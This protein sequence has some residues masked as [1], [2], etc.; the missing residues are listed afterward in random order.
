[1]SRI[2]LWSGVVF[3]ILGGYSLHTFA[4]QKNLE[5]GIFLLP[6]YIVFY[7]VVVSCFFISS[8]VAHFWEKAK[9]KAKINAQNSGLPENDQFIMKFICSLLGTATVMMIVYLALIYWRSIVFSTEVLKA[10]FGI[11]TY[12]V[13]IFSVAVFSYLYFNNR[14]LKLSGQARKSFFYLVIVAFS[15]V[16]IATVLFKVILFTTR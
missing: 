5:M 2:L 3:L 9:E 16:L 10:S 14:F 6:F 1:M 12:P 4:N 8:A 7:F 15:I 13:A 11:L